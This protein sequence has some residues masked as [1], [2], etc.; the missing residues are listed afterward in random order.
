MI[1]TFRRM[2]VCPCCP[3]RLLMHVPIWYP[4]LLVQINYSN[5]NN[6]SAAMIVAGWDAEGGGQVHTHHVLIRMRRGLM[7]W[8]V[9]G[10][11]CCDPLHASYCQSSL[12]LVE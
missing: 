7:R 2:L 5:K 6:L 11:I 1:P 3:K 10:S 8:C 4:C 9:V 12:P